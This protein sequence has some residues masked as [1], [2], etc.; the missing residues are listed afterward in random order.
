MSRTRLISL[1]VLAALVLSGIVLTPALAG[2]GKCGEPGFTHW[3]FCYGSSNEEMGSPVQKISGTDGVSI[4]EGKIGGSTAKVECKKGTF[5][6]EIG[7]S[8]TGKGT[9]HFSECKLLKPTACR[10]TT[11]EEENIQGSFTAVL[12]GKLEVPG[13]PEAEFTGSGTSEEITTIEIEN[14]TSECAD[15]GN[16]SI[17][18]KQDLELPEAEKKLVEHEFA[19]KKTGSNLKLGGEPASLSSTAKLKLLSPHEGATWYIGLGT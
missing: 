13:K 11:A 9:D 4:L 2:G 6:A 18:G 10:L 19:A 3:V 8:G 1:G 7:L 5:G 16:Y 15:A 17:S 14:K 12:I